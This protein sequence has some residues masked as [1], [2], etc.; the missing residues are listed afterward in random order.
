MRRRGGGGD[1]RVAATREADTLSHV[2]TT[3]I[4]ERDPEGSE[5]FDNTH[6]CHSFRFS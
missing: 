5:L 4:P 1:V 6:T 2:A 3:S